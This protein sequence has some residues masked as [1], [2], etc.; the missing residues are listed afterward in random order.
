MIRSKRQNN[1]ISANFG[2]ILTKKGKEAMKR[3]GFTLIELL[4]VI[5]IIGILAAILLPALA[6]ARE[7]ARRA[8]CANNLKQ[9]GIV[10]KMYAN[11]AGGLF[12]PNSLNP[13]NGQLGREQ[14]LGIRN[15]YPEYLTDLSVLFCPSAAAKDGTV[16]A[17]DALQDGHPIVYTR[18]DYGQQDIKTGTTFDTISDLVNAKNL[19]QYIS[20]T[21]NAYAT[22]SDSDYFGMMWAAHQT[23][24]VEPGDLVFDPTGKLK[25]GFQQDVY[26]YFIDNVQPTGSGGALPNPNGTVYRLREGVERFMLTDIY[27]PAAASLAQS[28]VPVM[29]D[30]VADGEFEFGGGG[31]GIVS[32]NH[33]PGGANVLFMDGHVEFIKYPIGTPDHMPAGDF[34]IGPFVARCNGRTIGPGRIF[35]FELQ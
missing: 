13:G 25:G 23:R 28:S 30:V 32:F 22:T 12:P 27:N 6:R 35:E 14:I 2:E 5:A 31:D 26:N 10:C 21:Y 24:P 1:F 33:V 11:E 18:Q 20:Y 15:V 34:P 19:G 8:S 7:A 17:I 9:M 16:G 3:K 4:V 29:W